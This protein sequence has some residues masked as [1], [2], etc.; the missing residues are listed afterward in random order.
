MKHKLR[1]ERQKSGELIFLS[2]IALRIVQLRRQEFLDK[3]FTV[4][5]FPVSVVYRSLC[6]FV[7]QKLIDFNDVLRSRTLMFK[8]HLKSQELNQKYTNTLHSIILQW[9]LGRHY[10]LDLCP[11]IVT[12]HTCS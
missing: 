7:H 4:I 2:T 8:V 1:M 11:R 10:N 12:L 5:T 3:I 9:R 6:S